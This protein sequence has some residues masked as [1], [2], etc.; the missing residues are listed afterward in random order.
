[1]PPSVCPT[2]VAMPTP[3]AV[4]ATGTQPAVAIASVMHATI[5]FVLVFMPSPHPRSVP[6]AA[7]PP[8]SDPSSLMESGFPRKVRD[9]SQGRKSVPNVAVERQRRRKWGPHLPEQV[10]VGLAHLQQLAPI[11]EPQHD[12]SFEVPAYAFDGVEVHDRRAMHLPEH[13]GVELFHE[14]LDRIADQPVALGGNH[15]GVLRIGLEILHLLDRDELDVLST[16]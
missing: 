3:T 12:M 11:L 14:L 6:I 15:P 9:S 10:L 13:R 4:T 16:R 1:M 5:A 8:K 2:P 7:R